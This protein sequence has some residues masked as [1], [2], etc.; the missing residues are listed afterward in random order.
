MTVLVNGKEI[1]S[2]EGYIFCDT[3]FLGM[4]SNDEELLKIVRELFPLKYLVIDPITKLEFLRDVFLPKQQEILEQFLEKLFIVAENNQEIF[5]RTLETGLLLSRIYAH[6]GRP[7]I[8][9]LDILLAARIM[10]S[11]HSTFLVTGNAKDFPSFIF[12]TTTVIN[13][14]QKDGVIRAIPILRFSKSRY[15]EVLKSYHKVSKKA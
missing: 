5:K 8:G 12:E 2:L 14:E 6:N 4:L 13:Y 15:A 11:P 1:Q 3:D 9:L 10:L 7:K